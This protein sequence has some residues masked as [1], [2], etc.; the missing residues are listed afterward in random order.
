MLR[1]SILLSILLLISCVAKKQLNEQESYHLFCSGFANQ[2][3][4]LLSTPKIDT[5]AL[6]DKQKFAILP[7]QKS[8]WFTYNN[9]YLGLCIPPKA[10]R[11][12]LTNDCG[13][14]YVTYQKIKNEWEVLEQKVTICPS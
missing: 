5:Q 9:K 13:S 1:L 7:E 8:L 2:Y 10:K 6:I 11:R 12:R 3:W 4:H 14:V